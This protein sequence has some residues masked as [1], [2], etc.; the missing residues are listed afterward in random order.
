MDA[1][2]TL[3][4]QRIR[5]EYE[6]PPPRWTHRTHIP[7]VQYE[8]LRKECSTP[9][10]FDALRLRQTTFELPNAQTHY[11]TCSYGSVAVISAPS[12]RPR[13][14]IPWDLWG[15]MLR[16]FSSSSSSSSPFRIF[17]LASP[18]LRTFPTHS[19]EPITP[20]NIN[21]GY[22]IPCRTDSIVIYRA[23][24][25]TRVLLH[26]LQHALC[27]DHPERGLDQ[28]EAETEA[29]A[30]ILYTAFL[31]RGDP[32]RWKTLW[33]RQW[34]WLTA[35][36]RRVEQ[37]FPSSPS[38]PFPFPWRYTVGKEETLRRWWS[39]L[40]TRT[41]TAVPSSLRLTVPPTSEQKRKENIRPSSVML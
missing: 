40:P 4:L 9:S 10:E 38:S 5:Q 1:L 32:S 6:H 3:L 2:L 13:E 17:F 36:N 37:H 29:W 33:A 20:Q 7:S 15:R 11:A 34:N 24:D 30:E 35:Q 26:E 8:W 31:S 12:I 39:H 41:A 23:E 19:S 22:T 14:D 28:V 16:L 21:G 25:A 27:L 18:S